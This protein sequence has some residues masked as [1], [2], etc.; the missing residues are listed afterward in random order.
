MNLCILIPAYNE[1]KRLKQ[2][3]PELKKNNLDI[4]VVDDGSEDET[5][6]VAAK[7]GAMVLRHETNSGKGQALR[8]GF[9]F[10]LEKGYD[11]V[12]TMDADLQHDARHIPDFIREYQ[13][14]DADIILGDRM[15]EPGS[16]PRLRYWTNKTT[17]GIISFITGCSMR[18]TQSGFRLIRKNVLRCL[19]LSTSKFDTES[20][21]LI[22]ALVKGFKVSSIPVRTIYFEDHGSKINPLIDTLRF[23]KLILMAVFVWRK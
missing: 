16:M 3:L 14:K 10:I 5:S 17:S 2:L 4:L 20:E 12:I 9:N 1:S 21:V 8:T 22:K 11:A 23:I 18:D 13:N 19:K 6:R 7:A 15:L